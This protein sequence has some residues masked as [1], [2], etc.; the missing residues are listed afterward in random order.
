MGT[1]KEKVDS[2]LLEKQQKIL[3]TNIK[4]GVTI[5]DVEGTV[6]EGQVTTDATAVQSEILEGKT[7]YISSGKVTG[8]MVNRGN[9]NIVPSTHSTE[10]QAGYIS[11]GTVNAVTASIDPNIVPEN[12]MRGVTILGV[13]GNAT[14]DMTDATATKADILAGKTAYLSDGINTG[15]MVNQG[16]QIITPSL[17]NQYIPQGY[18]NGRGYVKAIDSSVD[19]NIKP[20]NIKYGVTILGVTGTLDLLDTSDATANASTILNGQTAY[21]NGSKVTGTMRNNGTLNYNP[22]TQDQAISSGYTSGG[23]IR[24][25][26]AS[27]D[28]NIKAG[29]IKEGVTILG[30]TGALT[31]SGIDT[32]DA[33]ATAANILAGKTAYVDSAKITGTMTNRGSLTITPSTSQQTSGSGYYSSITTS[34]VTSSIDENI[35]AEN[36]KAGVTILGVTG[37]LIANDTVLSD[38]TIYPENYSQIR[39][40][41]YYRQLTVA[42]ADSRVDSNIQAQN[43]KK[44]V[45]I[46]GVTGTLET[47]VSYEAGTL[48]IMAGSYINYNPVEQEGSMTVT[49]FDEDGYCSCTDGTYTYIRCY[50][51][52]MQEQDLQ[53]IFNKGSYSRILF[54]SVDAEMIKGTSNLTT[55]VYFDSNSS[56]GTSVT[57]NTVSVGKHFIDVKIISTDSNDIT[58]FMPTGINIRQK[59]I[60]QV[61]AS[62]DAMNA[63]LSQA[64][65]TFG[66]IYSIS[67]KNMIAVYRFNG[68]EWIEKSL[69][70][71][72]GTV[73]PAEYEELED[74]ADDINGEEV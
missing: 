15:T 4:A 52:L 46:L 68:E 42:P 3:P 31:D 49:E 65:G 64:V 69:T 6:I 53:I 27:I 61:Y 36:I 11:G 19:N 20:N 56:V 14:I 57:Y 48:T 41:T 22:S 47:G 1:I 17:V 73:T 38:E 5:F 44:G 60:S 24:A 12:I 72:T 62:T 26:T 30:V 40:Y 8:N 71:Y 23:T 63:D 25:V 34:A 67:A 2:I 37:S 59:L 7:A 28:S 55:N 74:L 54:G 51:S 66:F 39:Y 58:K 29:N 33:D 9:L 35:L 50:F 43:I 10:L 70:D 13:L 32:S 18:H 16:T 21:V 45:T